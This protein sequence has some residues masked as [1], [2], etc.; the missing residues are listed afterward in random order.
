QRTAA[1]FGLQAQFFGLPTSLHAAFG[2]PGEPQQMVLARVAP[3]DED[4]ERLELTDRLIQDLTAG[5]IAATDALARL[6]A[7]VSAPDRWRPVA[8]VIAFALASA[9]AA[10]FFGGGAREVIA[11]A[12]I[13]LATGLLSRL[14]RR[15]PRFG[16][17][18]EATAAF[19]AV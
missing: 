10:R 8:T 4:L 1:W 7:I 5:R 18:F 19:L 6:A 12:G 3:G 15:V 9:A 11:G 14:P 2:E 17:V 16:Q 13:G